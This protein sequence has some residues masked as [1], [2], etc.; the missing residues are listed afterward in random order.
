MQI[1]NSLE[2]PIAYYI[3]AVS[4]YPGFP[5]LGIQYTLNLDPPPTYIS[6]LQYDTR[7]TFPPWQ[8]MPQAEIGSFNA[9]NAAR[10]EKR[11]RPLPAIEGI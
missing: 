4:M 2:L 1:R 8:G 9:C 10:C 6:K 11:P 7:L 3:S 5:F